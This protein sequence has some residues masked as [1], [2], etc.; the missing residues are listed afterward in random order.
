MRRLVLLAVSAL[1]TGCTAKA[2]A[3]AAAS[4]AGIVSLDLCADQMVLKLVDRSRIKAVSNEV[5]LDRN[6]VNGPAAGLPRL[7]PTIEEII[8]LRPAIIVKSY[9]GGPLLEGQLAKLGIK[10][11]QLDYAARL[12]DIPATIRSAAAK[13]DATRKGEAVVAQFEQQVTKADADEGHAAN[14]PTLVY[15]TPGGVTSGPETLIDDVIKAAGYRN[16]SNKSGWHNL[17]LEQLAGEKPDA[18]LTAFF[19]NRAHDQDA[20]TSARHPVTQQALNGVPTLATSGASVSCG[21]WMMGDVVEQLAVMRE[22]V[23]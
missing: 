4:P 14:R 7:R 16:Y 15:V 9:G 12:T 18:A 23:S 22:D 17:P 6:L 10:T 20:W 11:V 1:V 19:D 2:N 21:N 8:A 5:D 3:D 13:L